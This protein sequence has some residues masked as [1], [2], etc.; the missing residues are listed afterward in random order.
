MARL[1][2][3]AKRRKT[4][5]ERERRKPY[6]KERKLVREARKRISYLNEK[7]YTTNTMKVLQNA[8]DRL[9][10]NRN[11]S[12]LSDSDLRKLSNTSLLQQ[13]VDDKMSTKSGIKKTKQA[14]REKLLTSEKY[15]NISDVESLKIADIFITDIYHTLLEL[16]YLDSEQVVDLMTDFKDL[17]STTI[18]SKMYETFNDTNISR[19]DYY[20]ELISRLAE[21]VQV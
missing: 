21:Y 17:D 14:I 19:E 16:G 11:L 6:R 20:G 12:S 9:G 18:E 2:G 15:E 3:Q 7:G 4:R 13:F 5:A 8:L 1:R 10:I